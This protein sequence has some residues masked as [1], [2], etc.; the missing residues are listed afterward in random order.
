MATGK[1]DGSVI[2]KAVLETGGIQNAMGKIGG[3][4]KTIAGS[5]GGVTKQTAN[6][7]N[8][9]TSLGNTAK[10]VGG[11]IAGAF[12]VNKIINFAKEAIDL[13][14]DLSE[15]QNVVDNVFTT[16]TSKVNDFA[17][18]AAQ[19]YGL[20]ET[21]A[22]R[23]VGTFG[24]MAKAFGFTEQEAYD[25][26][27]TLTGLAGDVASFYN[28]DQD[29][30]YTKLKSVFSGETES[31]KDLG[32]VMTQTALD[33]YAL[34]NGIGKTTDKMTEQ[35]KVALR[36]RFILDQL[37]TA[38]GDF[39]RTSDGWANQ[40]RILRLQVD[41]LKASLGQGLINLLT[42]A[43]KVINAIIGRLATLA[44]AF[45]AFTELITGKKSS[46][47][48]GGAAAGLSDIS[49]AAADAADSTGSL[50]DATND[51]AGATKNAVKQQKEYLSGLDEMKKFSLS[52]AGSDSG[53]SGGGGGKG[54]GAGGGGGLIPA[55]ESVDYGKLA[56]G[57]SVVDELG[58]SFQKLADL[59]KS[60][61]WEGLGK[62][63][64]DGINAG[65]QK[66]YDFFNWDNLGPKITEFTDA[67]VRTVNS[68]VDNLDAELGG[69]TLGTIINT[70][71]NTI[72]QLRD[73]IDWV[74]I[75]SKI[76]DGFN[77]L[78]DEVDFGKLGR[79]ISS[80][81]YLAWQT[82]RGFIDN[83]H[84]E[85][86]G[87]HIAELMEGMMDGAPKLTE[88]GN[89]ICKLVNGAFDTLGAWLRR[90]PFKKFATNIS[91][92][93]NTMIMG[94][95]WEADG[96]TFNELLVK[97]GGLLTDIVAK[98]KWEELG[99]GIGTFLGQIDWATHLETAWN[100]IKNIVLGLARGLG[101]TAG[102]RFLLGLIAFKVT[103]TMVL[104]F[105]NSL[106]AAFTGTTVTSALSTSIGGS[107]VSAA[108]S[109]AATAGP[110]VA[111]ILAGIIAFE[112][113]TYEV[114]EN[115]DEMMPTTVYQDVIDA[116]DT[117]SSKAG[118]TKEKTDELRGSLAQVQDVENWGD[119]IDVAAESLYEAGISAEDLNTATD[120]DKIGGNLTSIANR[121]SDTAFVAQRLQETTSELGESFSRSAGTL[122]F[123]LASYEDTN[124][125]FERMFNVLCNLYNQGGDT[126]A[127]LPV[128]DEA[129]IK[130]Q[131]SGDD[132][133]QAF[134]RMRQ[135]LELAGYDTEAFILAM[136]KEF[137]EAVP[138]VV[139][140]TEQIQ[141]SVEGIGTAAETTRNNTQ[142]AANDT[143]AAWSAIA[144]EAG[145]SMESAAGAAELYSGD[146]A[147]S[148]NKN[149]TEAKKSTTNEWGGSTTEIE[150]NLNSQNAMVGDKLRSM[151]HVVDWYNQ[152]FK[153]MFSDAWSEISSNISM[154]MNNI[155]NTVSATFYSMTNS[156]ISAF[157]GMAS[158][159]S[160][161]L[162]DF[163]WKLNS[164]IVGAQNA[165]NAIAS[166]LSFNIRLDGFMAQKVGWSSMYLNIPQRYTNYRVPY[167]ASGAVIPPNAPFMAMLGDQKRGNNIEAPEDLIR[168]I[169]R[170]ESGGRDRNYT[171]IAQLNGRT[172]FSQMVTEAELRQ[173]QTGRNPFELA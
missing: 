129:F 37:S 18:T 44:N 51:A 73:G 69:R 133:Q 87:T 152:K 120:P 92:G 154:N 127:M 107:L 35:E 130:A 16:M 78:M 169:V 138:P 116:L 1:A 153:S 48:T 13:G 34:Q 118:L 146:A 60:K 132:A 54:S 156:V 19:A 140:S 12:A 22:K 168:K 128:L 124:D 136:Q 145:E 21:M 99:S 72:N 94:I 42:P 30:A 82:F 101:K 88:L 141:D 149:W 9:F 40:V 111:G 52:D 167:L 114:G 33:S 105:I 15:V 17:T 110:I 26:S 143:V 119:A 112:K 172:L 3:T 162:N 131:S 91:D 98:V 109:A 7:Q 64:A 66:L 25:M 29:A 79:A 137:P 11:I 24:A 135:A 61:D 115:P 170:E 46:G 171:F 123:S 41:S 65:M 106:A 58:E 14:S 155:G 134:D 70:A 147:D 113:T 47:Q 68:F 81:F 161:P 85:A 39:A 55:V 38:S 32:I 62:F 159:I 67:V 151:H 59:I 36:Y 74:E 117:L 173:M 63:M 96:Q 163:I 121:M 45:K 125:V 5:V 43:L 27:T 150:K 8:Q 102:G 71:V 148:L 103:T 10:K 77:G 20:S 49:G 31:L 165:Q 50:A 93:I 97:F 76:A 157:Q 2:I 28:I 166:L 84:F 100:L 56:E 80:K 4:V 23:Y 139:E 144:E 122:D 90:F 86:L 53:G 95:D 142:Q 89:T 160:N 158:G 104:P 83:F 57:S 164:L 75:G 6:L 108:K 126:A